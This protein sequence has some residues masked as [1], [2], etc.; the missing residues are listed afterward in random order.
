MSLSGQVVNS[1]AISSIMTDNNQKNADISV[2]LNDRHWFVMRDLKRANAKVPAYKML[3]EEG[4]EVFTPL[5]ERIVKTGV[6]TE[7][8]CVPVINDL[9][10]VHSTRHELDPIV[11]RTPTLQY[12]FVRGAAMGTVMEV[13]ESEMQRFIMAVTATSDPKYFSPEEITADMLGK[14]V[15]IVG[16]SLNGYEGFLL[17]VRGTRK[18]RLIVQLQGIITAAVEVNREFI[19]LLK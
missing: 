11:E 4:F 9:L 15:E 8:K 3:D 10:F 6:R 1:F 16:G 17:S 14:R 5:H 13:P 12:R 18:R 7:K 19:R 2:G